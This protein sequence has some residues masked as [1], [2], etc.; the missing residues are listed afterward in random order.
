MGRCGAASKC[1]QWLVAHVP[2]FPESF[3]EFPTKSLID[4]LSW[5]HKFLVD[6]PLT[7]KKKNEH[8]FDFGFAHSRFL[9][10]G[11]IL[12]CATPDFG[13]LSWGRTPKSVI[14][15]L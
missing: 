2:L 12:Q 1:V 10:K 4:S 5:C 9:G 3:K 11:E 6:D 14:H 15:H 13:V 8:L 7:V